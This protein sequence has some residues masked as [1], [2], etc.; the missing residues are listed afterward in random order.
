MKKMR[1]IL[2]GLY[3]ALVMSTT[4]HAVPQHLPAVDPAGGGGTLWQIT[5]YDDTAPAHTPWATQRICVF[6]LGVAGSNTVGLW[7]STTYNRWIGRFRQEGDEVKMIGDFW[8]GPGNDSI[9]W[10]IAVGDREGFGHWEE[11]IEDGLYGAWVAKGNTKLVRIG[12]CQW[13]PNPTPVPIP[14]EQMEKLILEQAE[15]AP[16][17]VRADGRPGSPTDRALVPLTQ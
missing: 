5:F 11:W 15:L 9:D 7:Y 12:T 13:A 8:K 16:R 2:L 1:R 17:R 14:L 4:A 10:E 6:N 3:F